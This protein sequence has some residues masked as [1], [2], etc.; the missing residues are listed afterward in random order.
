MRFLRNFLVLNLVVFTN[1]LIIAQSSKTTLNE[2]SAVKELLNKKKNN[3]TSTAVNDKFK[4]QIFYGKSPEAKSALS[5]FRRMYP[6][7]NATIVYTNPSYKVMVGN[8]KTRLDAERNLKLIQK[9]FE[10]A[11]LI[12]PGK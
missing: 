4:I 3:N 2:P 9:D 12:R 1:N 11:L 7:V 5:T 8:Y 10:H 6:D